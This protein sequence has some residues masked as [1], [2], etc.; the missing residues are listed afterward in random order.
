MLPDLNAIA[1]Y[2]GQLI[3]AGEALD[4]LDMPIIGFFG[5]DDSSIAVED[6]NNFKLILTNLGKTADINLYPGVGHAFANPSGQNYT[7]AA[8][9][10]AWARTIAFFAR[11]LQ[12]T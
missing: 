6:V 11:Y 3:L 4:G 5:E 2:Y 12:N 8:A 1:I 7:A 9:E 10:D